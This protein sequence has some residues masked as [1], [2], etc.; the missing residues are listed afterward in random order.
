[1]LAVA[2][3]RLFKPNAVFIPVKDGKEGKDF[4]REDCSLLFVDG[5]FSEANV[6]T[7]EAWKSDDE[8]SYIQRCGDFFLPDGDKVSEGRVQLLPDA[9]IVKISERDYWCEEVQEMTKSIFGVYA[10]DRRRHFHLCEFCASY[11]LWFIESQYDDTDEVLEDE[12]KRDELFQMILEGDG[13]TEPVTYWHVKD[14]EPMFT[15]GRRCHPGWLPKTD[16]GGG[17]RLRDFRSVTWDG[18]MEEI[19]ESRCNSSI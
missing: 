18:V 10:F 5:I 12:D 1:M 17:Y 4:D 7:E 6:F 19:F 14:I 3:R 8:P 13:Y 9:C 16:E 2:E 15:R 11:E